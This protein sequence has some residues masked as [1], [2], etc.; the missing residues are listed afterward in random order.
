MAR[1][2]KVQ[3]LWLKTNRRLVSNKTTY[4]GLEKF[5]KFGV[6][7]YHRFEQPESNW[8]PSKA[9]LFEYD[10]V[11]NKWKL[12]TLEEALHEI[13]PFDLKDLSGKSINQQRIM[14]GLEPINLNNNA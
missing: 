11:L 12:I 2:F 13:N 14:L 6:K 5:K 7:L 9:E 8:R 10:E 4:I 3:R 1:I